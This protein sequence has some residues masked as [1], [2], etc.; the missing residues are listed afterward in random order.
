MHD[1]ASEVIRKAYETLARVDAAERRWRLEERQRGP[2][3]SDEPV[4]DWRR[5][6]TTAAMTTAQFNQYCR[7]GK[8]PLTAPAVT[9]TKAKADAMVATAVSRERAHVAQRLEG[10]ASLMGEEVGRVERKLRADFKAEIDA[11]RAELQELRGERGAE[12]LD[13]PDWRH[14]TH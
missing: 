9:V 4:A 8:P 7:D 11:L 5:C 3:D 10:F 2:V 1:D 13:L 12:A 14:A 6:T